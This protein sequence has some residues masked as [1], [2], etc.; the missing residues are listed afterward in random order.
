MVKSFAVHS[1]KGG[2]GKSTLAANL[3]VALAS[4]GNRVGLM[5][6]DLEGP[7]LHVIFNVDPTRLKFTLNDVLRDGTS[8]EQATVSLGQQLGFTKGA[9]YFTPASVKV[10]DILKTLR[11]GF[12]IESFSHALQQL[13]KQFSLDYLLIDTHPGVENDTL[14]AMGVCQHLLLVSRIDQ[15]DIFG[16]GVMIE[17]ARRLEKPVHL[18]LNMVPSR[19]DKN[20]A[21]N[22]A[23]QIGS[24]FNVDVLGWLPFSESLME[25]LSKSVFVLTL[26]KHEM[27]KRFLELASVI[28]KLP[29]E[30]YA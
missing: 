15:Q 6:M 3:A 26:Q 18:V 16:T 8:P 29:A 1:F 4:S 2:T 13:E 22:L 11:S 27:T 25:L 19:M 28:G 12:E 5:D 24:R 7:G 17:V 9:L 14:L 30:Q 20:D 21:S 10:S 23:R